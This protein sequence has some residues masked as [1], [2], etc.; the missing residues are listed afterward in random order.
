M[1]AAFKQDHKHYPD[2]WHKIPNGV[3]MRNAISQAISPFSR[4]CFGYHLLKIG[5]L[6]CDVELPECTI[7]HTIGLVKESHP[8][9][10]IVADTNELPLTENSIDAVLACLE[11]D[12]SADPHQVLREI[13]RVITPNGHLMLVGL[14]PFSLDWLISLLPI[15]RYSMLRHARYF[16]QGRVCDWLQL[17]GFEIIESKKVAHFCLSLKRSGRKTNW[18][19]RVCEKYF[20]WSGSGYIVIARKREIPLSL[21]KPSWRIKPKFSALGASARIKMD[22]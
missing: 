1:K 18:L 17:L 8:R 16:R 19:N 3:A 22:H 13:D 9:A 10:S 11:L 2:G 20:P 12:F 14:N 6:S 21:V 15:K 7:G 4:I 5:N